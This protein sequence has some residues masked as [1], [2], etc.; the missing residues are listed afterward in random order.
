MKLPP[1]PP[2]RFDSYAMEHSTFGAVQTSPP[3]ADWR[4]AE[5]HGVRWNVVGDI[6]HDSGAKLHITL[7][8]CTSPAEAEFWAAIWPPATKIICTLGHGFPV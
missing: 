1:F 5:R 6:N 7:A 2:T 8:Q 3:L 4:Y